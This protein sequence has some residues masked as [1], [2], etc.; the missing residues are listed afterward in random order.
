MRLP[1]TRDRDLSPHR[2]IESV[3]RQERRRITARKQA[4]PVRT[5]SSTTRRG[6]PGGRPGP[7]LHGSP[8]GT[9]RKS[10]Q[11]GPVSLTELEAGHQVESWCC[12]CQATPQ[13]P[14]RPLEVRLGLRVRGRGL[15]QPLSPLPRSGP[16]GSEFPQVETPRVELKTPFLMG[17]FDAELVGSNESL[18]VGEWICGDRESP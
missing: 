12:G 7:C 9:G 14:W 13:S 1:L 6:R 5:D 2:S 17:G 11:L 16:L 3:K 15:G 18:H 4:Q 10:L 8:A